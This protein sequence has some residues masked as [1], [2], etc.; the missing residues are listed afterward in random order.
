MREPSPNK[1]KEEDAEFTSPMGKVKRRLEYNSPLKDKMI[2]QQLNRGPSF[3][4]QVQPQLRNVAIEPMEI[5][6]QK[7]TNFTADEELLVGKKRR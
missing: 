6:D 5:D 4:E 7:S 3:E 1:F 2:T